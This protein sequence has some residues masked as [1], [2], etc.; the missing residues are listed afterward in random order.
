MWPSPIANKVKSTMKGETP[1]LKGLGALHPPV[2]LDRKTD[3]ANL[4][5]GKLLKT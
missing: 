5:A 2:T 3:H 1:S 4:L